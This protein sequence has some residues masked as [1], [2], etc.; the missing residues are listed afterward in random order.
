MYLIYSTTH[1]MAT[2][3][4]TAHPEEIE[5]FRQ[6][7]GGFSPNNRY[8]YTYATRKSWEYI[9]LLGRQ[10]WRYFTTKP[11]IYAGVWL[12]SEQRG[13]GDG[14]DYWEVFL[15][16]DGNEKIVSWDYDGTLC[17]RECLHNI[18]DEIIG[19]VACMEKTLP[20]PAPAPEPEPAP[21]PVCV[22][23]PLSL[24]RCIFGYPCKCSL[25]DTA[26]ITTMES[27]YR[28]YP[29]IGEFWCVITSLFYGSSLLLYFVKEED[30]FEEWRRY[31][32]CGGG[33]GLEEG[34]G[35]VAGV[36]SFFG[37]NIGTGDDMLGDI[38]HVVI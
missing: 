30:W 26:E 4:A 19:R 32:I 38:P 17:W 9:P 27:K 1:R 12:R 11:F 7:N 15:D 3:T 21:A 33:G 16:D 10:D 14:G 36:Y 29:N 20:E 28:I 25:F 31:A 13:F 6:P 37:S 23:E 8:E 2:T 34:G 22:D 18:E 24:L 5:C 35:W